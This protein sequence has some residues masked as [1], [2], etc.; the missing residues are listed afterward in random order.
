MGTYKNK[1]KY[2]TNAK[3]KKQIE[4]REAIDNIKRT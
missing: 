2:I 4:N 1:D 3:E